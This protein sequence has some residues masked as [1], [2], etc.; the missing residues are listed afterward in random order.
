MKCFLAIMFSIV[1]NRHLIKVWFVLLL[2]IL[3][4][5]ATILYFLILQVKELKN[6]YRVLASI[7]SSSVEIWSLYLQVFRMWQNDMVKGQPRRAMSRNDLYYT[8]NLGEAKK[9]EILK[10]LI[11]GSLS[12]QDAKL[13][14]QINNINIIE[15][16]IN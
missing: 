11:N 5:Y 3:E 8:M 4:M 15:I 16:Y 14:S 2:E 12:W 6:K 10:G 7:C 13:V 9:E 1:F